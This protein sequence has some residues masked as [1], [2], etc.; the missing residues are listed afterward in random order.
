MN[1]HGTLGDLLMA[2]N[3]GNGYSP[4]P[5]GSQ[6]QA[7]QDGGTSFSAYAPLSGASGKQGSEEPMYR[8]RVTSNSHERQRVGKGD[9]FDGTLFDV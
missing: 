8:P 6:A 2:I 9:M 7:Q 1:P 5:R 3:T 4:H